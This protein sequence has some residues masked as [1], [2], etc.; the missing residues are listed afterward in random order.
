MKHE[1]FLSRLEELSDD[2]EF[3]RAVLD[4]ARSCALCRREQRDADG[5]LSRV[6]ASPRSR[7]AEVGLWI[8]AAA[9][10][11]VVVIGL[12]KPETKPVEGEPEARY[13]VVGNVNGVVAYTPEGIVAGS[14]APRATKREV[15]R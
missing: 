12:R 10:L 3:V 5:L 13:R 11:A 7:P 8:A 6:E 4:H 14:L 1:E 2:S 9:L 15:S